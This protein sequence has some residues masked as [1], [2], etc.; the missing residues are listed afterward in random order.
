MYSLADVDLCVKVEQPRKPSM[1]VGMTTVMLI[2]IL[3]LALGLVLGVMAFRK[4]ARPRGQLSPGAGHSYRAIYN[5]G[6]VLSHDDDVSD[7]RTRKDPF[8]L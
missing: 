4:F 1:M 5:Q 3:I 7:S 2:S 6:A 8:E